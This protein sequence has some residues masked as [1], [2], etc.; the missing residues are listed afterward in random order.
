MLFYIE[1]A[2]K[3][4]LETLVDQLHKEQIVNK[5]LRVEQLRICNKFQSEISQLQ[6]K[7]KILLQKLEFKRKLSRSAI[8][9]LKDHFNNNSCRLNGIKQNQTRNQRLHLPKFSTSK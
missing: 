7:E 5:R 4:E 9:P 2:L 8:G 1:L 3:N 6:M